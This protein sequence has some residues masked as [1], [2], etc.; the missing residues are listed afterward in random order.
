MWLWLRF[1][2]HNRLLLDFPFLLVSDE[3]CGLILLLPST[4][5]LISHIALSR[6]H[7]CSLTFIS[8]FT[9]IKINYKM[10]IAD[11]WRYL[12]LNELE[13][14]NKIECNKIISCC[15]FSK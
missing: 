11:V 13:L 5:G 7:L 2:H 8:I 14:E 12:F 9:N 1:A 15:D 10:I 4:I 3:G 6:A